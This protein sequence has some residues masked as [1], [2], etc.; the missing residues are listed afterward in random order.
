VDEGLL[1]L[2]DLGDMSLWERVREAPP[3]EA[4]GWYRKAIDELLVLQV[5][6][7]RA[8]DDGCMAFRQAFDRRLYLWELAHFTE[9]G[10]EQ[11][12]KGSLPATERRALDAAF[13]DMAEHL[14]GQPRVLNHRDYHSWNL[15]VHDGAV[16]VIDFQDALLAPRQ[17]DLA[18]LLNDRETDRV[19]TPSLEERLVDYYVERAGALGEPV[20][21]RDAFRR[22]YLLSALQRDLKVVGRF[23]YLDLVKGKP[24]YNRYIP[25]TLERIGRNLRR[26]PG[27]ERLT[28]VLAGRFGEIA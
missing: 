3:E 2:E 14:A 20:P 19:V 15:M 7:T 10:L 11:G 8:R 4:A 9:Y 26:A 25:P 28:A 13:E 23:R 1:L 18:S 24:G 6:G 27:L 12:N 21:D 17:Y 5:A 22:T 16:A